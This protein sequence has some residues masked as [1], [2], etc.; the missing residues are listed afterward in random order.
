MSYDP[1]LNPYPHD[2]EEA[3]RLL[4]QVG[5]KGEKINVWS[6]AETPNLEQL[7]S[8]RSSPATGGRSAWT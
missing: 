2:P 5:Y 8:T 1:G 3:K 6:Y 7:E 4:Q